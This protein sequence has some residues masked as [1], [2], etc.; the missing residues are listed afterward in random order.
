MTGSGASGAAFLA[1]LDVVSA[2]GSVTGFDIGNSMFMSPASGIRDGQS[3]VRLVQG[4]ADDS[5]HSHIRKN[6]PAKVVFTVSMT[7]LLIVVLKVST[8]THAW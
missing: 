5:H 2:P 8:A 3:A 6:A 7:N 4:T 1:S